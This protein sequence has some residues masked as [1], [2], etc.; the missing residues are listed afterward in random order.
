MNLSKNEVSFLNRLKE[1]F[2]TNNEISDLYIELYEDDF[3]KP[4][5]LIFSSFHNTLNQLFKY[6]NE[7]LNSRYF[8]ADPCRDTFAIFDKIKSVL[9]TLK[10]H[11]LILCDKYQDTFDELLNFLNYYGG[12]QVP[13]EFEKIMIE[14]LEPIFLLEDSIQGHIPNKVLKLIPI[15]KGSYAQVYKYYDDYYDSWFA[16]KKSD[17]NLTSKELIRF[18]REFETMKSINSPYVVKVFKY[19]SN[20]KSYSMELLD[21]TLYQY[22]QKNNQKIT[23]KERFYFTNQ[24]LRAFEDLA[25]KEI[26]HR[27]ISPNNILIQD[28]G[29]IKIL[30]ISD[31]GLVKTKESL[32]TSD[33][34]ELRGSLNDPTLK[35]ESFKNYNITHETYAL[36]Q[37]IAMIVSGKFNLSKVK[38]QFIRDFLE[39]GISDKGS[40]YQ[41]ILELKIAY[42]KMKKALEI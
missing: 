38:N 9:D 1:E 11:K 37:L 24:I 29:N 39:T 18:E 32:L 22:L 36:T 33:G 12:T 26:L 35:F 30:K 4:L 14:E 23:Q 17:A 20:E 16:L 19:N 13:K 8:H 27:D 21:T 28:F 2:E 6:M 25:F 42:L 31:F 40:R 34:S 10:Q 5:D 41:N 15:G 3:D 7:Q